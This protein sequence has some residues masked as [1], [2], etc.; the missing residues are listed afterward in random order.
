MAQ[1][2]CYNGSHYCMPLPYLLRQEAYKPKKQRLQTGVKL[3]AICN[4]MSKQKNEMYLPA[5]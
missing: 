2:Q 4:P 5:F 3:Y 1:M